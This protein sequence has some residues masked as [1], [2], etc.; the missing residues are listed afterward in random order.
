MIKLLYNKHLL[1]VVVA[2]AC[3]GVCTLYVCMPDVAFAISDEDKIL[4]SNPMDGLNI[5]NIFGNLKYI[6]AK[7]IYGGI[8]ESS[9]AAADLANQFMA[10]ITNNSLFSLGIDDAKFN[11]VITFVGNVCSALRPLGYYFVGVFCGIEA[12]RIC[13]DTRQLSSQWFG[14]GVIEAWLVFSIK[15]CVLF[16]LVT[17]AKQLMYAIYWLV[18]RIQV[19]VTKAISTA[20]L[21]GVDQTF[22]CISDLANNLTYADAGQSFLI[23]LVAIIALGAAAITAIY[24]QVLAVMRL[25]EIFILIAISPV[26]I[27]TFASSYTS[28]IA[29]G[30]I[31]T[32]IG[33][34]LQISILFLIVA[35]AGPILSSVAG[36]I[37]SVFVDDQATGP[38]K[39]LQVVTPIVTALALFL[40][41]KKSREISDRLAGAN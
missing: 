28:S 21:G 10:T 8:L 33:A 12:L 13:K 24:V 2:C 9:N 16:T 37:N 26:S 31:K 18:G 23:L 1:Y 15:Y 19:A 35:I 20:G 4:E 6:I 27:S 25:F 17:N 39:L 30:Y 41:A 22:N 5:T 38:A 29:G 32:F 40:M 11:N 7:A 34:V 14:L 36:S 3:I